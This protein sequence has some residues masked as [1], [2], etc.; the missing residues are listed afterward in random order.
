MML[1][2][3]M[4]SDSVL[5]NPIIFKNNMVANNLIKITYSI[6]GILFFK[7]YLKKMIFIIYLGLLSIKFNA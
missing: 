2:I 6:L 7:I 4:D 3:R 1:V 5:L